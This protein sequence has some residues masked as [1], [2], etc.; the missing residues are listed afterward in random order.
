MLVTATS[1]CRVIQ[2]EDALSEQDFPFPGKFGPEEEKNTELG[3]SRPDV[4][5]ASYSCKQKRNTTSI[6]LRG[7]GRGKG[8][9]V[10]GGEIPQ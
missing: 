6:R 1:Q 9:G 7:G 2:R 4:N 10:V 5:T 3:L 8:S